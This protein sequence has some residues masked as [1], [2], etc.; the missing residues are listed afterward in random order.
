MKKYLFALVLLCSFRCFSQVPSEIQDPKVIHIN[1]LPARTSVWPAPSLEAAATTDYDH[2]PWVKS[3]NGKWMFYWSPDPQSRPADFYLPGYSR[4]DR[5]TI[6]VPSTMERQGFGTPVY[7]NSIYPFKVNP[8]FVMEEPPAN[9]TAYK[10]RNPV[11]SYC[12][13]FTV[14]EDWNDKQIILHLA[15]TSSASFVWVNGHKVGYSQDSRLPAEFNITP[16]LLRGENLLAVEVYKYCDGSYLEDQDYWRLSGIYRDVFI[17][18]VPQ[19]TCWDVYAQ[20]VPDLNKKEGSVILHYRPANFSEGTINKL[21][22]SV[23]VTSPTGK[24]MGNKKRFELNAFEPGIGKEMVLPEL[25]LGPIELWNDEKPVQ[26]TVWVELLEKDK[27]LEAYKLPVAFRKIEVKGNT[28][29]LNGQ[30]FKIRGVNRH[31]FSPHQGWYISKEDMV[32]DIKLMK[33]ANINFV[34]TSHYPNDPRWYELCNEYGMMLMDEANVESHELSYLRKGLPG[35][36]PVWSAACVDRMERMVIR[37]R[38]HPCVFM[39]SFGNEAGYGSAFYDMRK[40]THH[41]DPETRL[42]QYCDMNAAADFDS[43]TYP[44]IDWINRHLQGKAVRKGERGESTNEEQHGKY[45]SGRPF[46]FNEYAH[47]MGNS[48]GNFKDFWDLFYEND[49]LVGGFV[50]DWMDQFLLRDATDSESGFLYGG[51]FKDFPNDANFCGNGLIGSDRIPHPH[52]YELKKVYQPIAFRQISRDPLVV[53][54]TNYNH[55]IGLAEYDFRYTVLQ[56]GEVVFR[57]SPESLDVPPLG[58]NRFVLPAKIPCDETKECFLNMEFSLK[59]DEK[60]AEKGFITAYEQVLLSEGKNK[61][62]EEV[63]VKNIPDRKESETDYIIQGD[64]FKVRFNKTTGL[65]SEYIRDAVPI[66]KKDVKFNFWRAL[67]DNDK[68][69]KTDKIMKV[70]KEESDNCELKSMI[71]TSPGN[72]ILV[73]SHCIFRGTGSE[74]TVVHTLYPDGSIAIDFNLDIPAGAPPIPR[75]GLTFEINKSMDQIEWYGRGPMENYSD[76]KSGALVGIYSSSVDEWVTPY[77]RPQENAN[78]CDVRWV[79]FKGS[80]REL[81]ISTDSV[82]FSVSA[83]PYTLEMLEV[84]THDFELGQAENNIVNIDCAQMGVGGDNS[85]GFPVNESYLLKPGNY[86]YKFL[87]QVK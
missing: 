46:V 1:K 57:S 4:S 40:A 58:K 65:I 44:T 37:D 33:Q 70:W 77:V 6:D 78:R 8:P 84:A 68:G 20:P 12:R 28:M 81:S 59:E 71:C 7:T 55:N 85:W 50:W 5:T 87:I 76:R 79:K 86:R 25:E 41:R 82:P 9:Y 72:I 48:L 51:D 53:E 15:G 52:Y 19:Y 63:S 67:T 61:S 10:E 11:G 18:A 14:P 29:L 75:I 32:R 16:Y 30:K 42:I 35:D 69:W 27:T 39:W 83:W 60:W 74:G 54:I 22:A 49:L 3:L 73:S 62:G 43:Q 45:P 38:Q 34:R 17:R 13:Y 47:A 21:T 24:L 36:D 64:R 26:Y 80:D 31:E 2:S 56:E 23:Y 66:I